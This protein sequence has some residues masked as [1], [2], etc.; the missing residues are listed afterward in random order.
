MNSLV[1]IARTIAE[2][3]HRGQTRRDGTTPY[4]VHPKAV[5]ERVGDSVDCVA[6]AWL[7]DVLEDSSMTADDLRRRG[8]TEQVIVAVELLTRENHTAYDEYLKRIAENAIARRVKIADMLT[9]LSDAPTRRQIRK[10][11]SGLLRLVPE[12][13]G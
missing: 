9:N 2:E 6:A 1:E 13:D 5:A 7:H 11:A 3:A 10:Y 12:N 8:V 4:I